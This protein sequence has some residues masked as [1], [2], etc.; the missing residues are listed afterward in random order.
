MCGSLIHLTPTIAITTIGFLASGPAIHQAALM[1][2]TSGPS[3]I[4][5]ELG[6]PF[7]SGAVFTFFADRRAN[8]P[9][10]NEQDPQT[11]PPSG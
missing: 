4:S 10:Q 5:V 11:S 8:P 3:P 2:N 7:V 9:A 6:S 1:T